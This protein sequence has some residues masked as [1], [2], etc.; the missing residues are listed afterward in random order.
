[1]LLS[2]MRHC[3]VDAAVQLCIAKTPCAVAGAG[4]Q[5][6]L[7]QPAAGP[8]IKATAATATSLLLHPVHA[9]SAQAVVH[10]ALL[11]VPQR[12]IGLADLLELFGCFRVVLQTH[13]CS[14]T[15]HGA[16]YRFPDILEQPCVRHEHVID[17]HP[18]FL[19]ALYT[20]SWQQ[21]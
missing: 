8:T 20:P 4:R 17:C 6:C 21:I 1:M 10:P 9:L 3:S 11:R 2:R 13:R 18:A 15:A 12:L 7:L 19:V 5:L 16:N 14:T